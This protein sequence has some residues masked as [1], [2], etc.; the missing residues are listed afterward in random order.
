M[1]P[2]AWAGSSG[3]SC[4]CGWLASTQDRDKGHKIGEKGYRQ[5]PRLPWTVP[6]SGE[7]LDHSL[8]D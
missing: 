2:A 8:R 3:G 1:L 7:I 6:S 4:R 5:F